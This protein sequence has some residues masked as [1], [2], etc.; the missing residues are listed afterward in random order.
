MDY[1]YRTYISDWNTETQSVNKEN[2]TRNC[3]VGSPVGMSHCVL[4]FILCN[5]PIL[6][7]TKAT[8]DAK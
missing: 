1:L 6:G 7:Q 3:G 8:V 2:L 5:T 4:Y